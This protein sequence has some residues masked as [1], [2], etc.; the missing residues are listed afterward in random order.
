L[1]E[2]CF[3][4]GII[5]ILAGIAIPNYLVYQLQAKATEATINLHTIAYL[6][7]VAILETGGPIACDPQPAQ[8]PGRDRVRF[9]PDQSWR[10]L[11]FVPEARVVYQYRVDKNGSDGFAAV[12]RGDLDADGTI[13]EYRIDSETMELERINP[14]H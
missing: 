13:S 11:G 10:D 8:I 4:V 5:G 7:Q 1:I 2:L 9:V 12:A 14:A 3:V 6:E